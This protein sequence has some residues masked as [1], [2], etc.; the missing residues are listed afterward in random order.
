MSSIPGAY[1]RILHFLIS[2]WKVGQNQSF[3][4]VRCE[5]ENT[6]RRQQISWVV[7][8]CLL[9]AWLLRCHRSAIRRLTL[10][11]ITTLQ[12]K[13]ALISLYCRDEAKRSSVNIYDSCKI[14]ESYSFKLAYGE[15]AVEVDGAAGDNLVSRS[16]LLPP[17]VSQAEIQTATINL[18][19]TIN[20]VGEKAKRLSGDLFMTMRLQY[21]DDTP[22]DYVPPGFKKADDVVFQFDGIPANIRVGIVKTA[23]HSLKMHLQTNRAFLPLTKHLNEDKMEIQ[24]AS[25]KSLELKN[26][27]QPEQQIPDS[28][29]T[30]LTESLQKQTLQSE[31]DSEETFSVRCPCGVNKDDGVM[32]LCDGCGMWQHAVCFRILEETDVP[33]SHIC[34]KCSETKPELL[35]KGGITDNSLKG[36]PDDARKSLCLL[37]RAVLLC[38]SLDSISPAI[39][40]K[41]LEVK[42]TVARSL[43]NR[44]IDEG[45]LKEVGSKR[46]EK[47]VDKNYLEETVILKIFQHSSVEIN[48][49]S[50]FEP[51]SQ[52]GHSAS[53]PPRSVR[54]TPRLF[55]ASQD[56]IFSPVPP[57]KRRRT[58]IAN[59]PVAIFRR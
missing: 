54:H 43:F 3:Y 59:T 34:E 10:R 30:D 26:Q 27:P 20:A 18:L 21:T 41:N 53:S 38:T 5:V 13:S 28:K 40:S 31:D 12:L 4:T 33:S 50:S 14:V 17:A 39:I 35:Q 36:L 6:Q 22:E 32:I 48:G 8:S 55:E 23:H 42:Y 15:S 46:G 2:S 51:R 45:I 44:L 56:S 24:E 9:V 37:R 57:R 11:N 16:R 25:Q 7:E 19:K 52:F 58:G 49:T 47:M 29:E 1:S